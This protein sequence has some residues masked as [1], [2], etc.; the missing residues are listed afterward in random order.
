MEE[1]NKQIAVVAFGGN[2]LLPENQQGTFAEQQ[3]NADIAAEAILEIVRRGYEVII[4]HGNGPQVGQI[5]AQNEES[6]DKI[7]MMPLDCCGAA[8]QGQIGYM[9]TTA[10]RRATRKFGIEKNAL[11]MLTSV[12][13]S[14][15]DEAFQ[16]PTKPIGGF[17]TREQAN[18]LMA[19]KKWQMIEDSGRGYR[20][21]VPSPRPKKILEADAIRDLAL[22]GNIVISC[23]GGGIPV[24]SVN[25]Q[26][27]GVEAV[28][29][30]DF[31]SSLLAAQIGAD[32]YIVLTGVSQVA[33]NFGQPNVQYLNRI[34]VA[35][36]E[37]YMVEGQ[38][39]P[40]SMGP[41]IKAALDYIHAGGK[42]VLITMAEELEAALKGETGTYI[43]P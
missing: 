42:E 12:V 20:R 24:A 17:F 27:R 34:T 43:V 5:L 15:E 30:K 26:F 18:E 11:A 41:K 39:P 7:P 29:D 8:S 25:G 32:I 19:S 40:G 2:A 36:A 38:F 37:K 35:E 4:V 16:N 28:I 3:A 10:M 14:P 23:G 1:N 9:L 6:A 33:I 22:A 13:V 31:A 21:V